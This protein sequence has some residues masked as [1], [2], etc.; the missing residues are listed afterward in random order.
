[1][2]TDPIRAVLLGVPLVLYRSAGEVVCFVDRCP[3]RRA[4][5]SLGTCDG[6]T[7]QCAYH[8]WRFGGDGHCT[9]IPAL[10]P[11][12]TI[13]RQARLTPVAAVCERSAMVF[14]APEDPIAPPGRIAESEDPTFEMGELPVIRA[15]ASV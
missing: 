9:E 6:E 10:G 12:A 11:M 13:P 7:L 4:P 1:M 8:G 2:T 3:H 15:R 5:L 14:V